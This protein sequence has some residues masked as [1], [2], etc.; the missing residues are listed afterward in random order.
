MPTS[1]ELCMN[2]GSYHVDLVHAVARQGVCVDYTLHLNP[3]VPPASK[4]EENN[5]HGIHNFHLVHAAAREG[6]CVDYTLHLNLQD[7]A[8][9][10]HEENYDNSRTQQP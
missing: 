2:E 10:E 5:L 6:V 4:W 8:T 7:P 1:Y 9:S 3:C